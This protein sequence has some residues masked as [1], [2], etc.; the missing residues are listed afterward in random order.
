LKSGKKLVLFYCKS[1][2]GGAGRVGSQGGKKGKAKKIQVLFSPHYFL[3]LSL[4]RSLARAF[5]L[6]FSSPPP[7]SALLISFLLAAAGLISLS[8]LCFAY[9]FDWNFSGL[10][11]QDNNPR[12]KE[13]FHRRDSPR[14]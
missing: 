4:A 9:S 5:H 11:K 6:L 3:P 13:W 8:L 2:G 7:S 12:K 10:L 1:A 14:R